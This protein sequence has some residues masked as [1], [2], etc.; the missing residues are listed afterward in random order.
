M[1]VELT[2]SKVLLAEAFSIHQEEGGQTLEA[3]TVCAQ[4]AIEDWAEG[5][6]AGV[7]FGEETADAAG[8][9]G[10]S[11]CGASGAGVGAVCD[12]RDHCLTGAVG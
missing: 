9:G 7:V 1:G 4:L 11:F 2:S 3:E 5:V 6:E 8:A 12:R 10:A